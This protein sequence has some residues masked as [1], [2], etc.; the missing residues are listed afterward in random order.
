MS[1]DSQI[2]QQC[3]QT[4]SLADQALTDV[5]SHVAEENQRRDSELRPSCVRLQCL[6]CRSEFTRKVESSEEEATRRRGAA[7][8]PEGVKEQGDEEPTE[9]DDDGK[10]ERDEK[11]PRLSHVQI[12]AFIVVHALMLKKHIIWNINPQVQSDAETQESGFK[13]S[14][15]RC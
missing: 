5:L 15:T 14:L 4:C 8:L 6:R 9:G 3:Q 10:G 1:A 12:H 2:P 13:H 11:V 7:M